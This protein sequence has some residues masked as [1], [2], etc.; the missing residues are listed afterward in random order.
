MSEQ[1]RPNVYVVFG[2]AVKPD[3]S[4]SGTL[5]RRTLGAWEFSRQQVEPALFIVSGGLGKYPPAEAYVM[6]RILLDKGVDAA[7]IIKDLDAGDTLDTVKN[8]AAIIRDLPGYA[9]LYVCTSPYHSW[10]CQLLLRMYKLPF[11]RA[12]MPGDRAELG[13]AKWLYY[14]LKEMA[15]IAWDALLVL[16][17]PPLKNREE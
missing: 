7:S 16:L 1:Q 4:P 14:C 8:T 3:G 9:S 6:E 17:G 10:R 11:Q 12:T 15:A 2:A 5:Q 13:L